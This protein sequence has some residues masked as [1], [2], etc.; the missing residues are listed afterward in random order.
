MSPTFYGVLGV[1]PDADADAIRRGYR[2]RAR[3]VHPDVNDEPD[4]D[5]QF[6]RLATAK[7]TLL[8]EGERERYDRLGHAS[9]VRHH[10]SGSAWD[11]RNDE[12]TPSPGESPSSPD[13]DRETSAD[14][15]SESSRRTR[16]NRRRYGGGTAGEAAAE[17][18]STTGARRHADRGAGGFGAG[19]SA[20]SAAGESW[21]TERD[22][23]DRSSDE[24]GGSRES[25]SVGES[26]G[27][28]SFW[29][30]QRVGERYSSDSQRPHP[31]LLGLIRVVRALGPWVV[32]HVVFLSLSVAS[33]AYVYAVVASEHGASLPLLFVLVGAVIVA[34]LL[35][36]MHALTQ[37]YR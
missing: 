25:R 12:P 11:V 28:S 7:E 24:S 26:Y 31:V 14:Q 13:G 15:Q 19:A 5:F 29:D 1:E 30:S 16:S 3:E 6:R 8:D 10:A 17:A 22:S 35:S 21:W 20:T 2:E 34:V 36:T 4:A 23:R 27:A 9:Y 32:V 33:A 18:G 37:V